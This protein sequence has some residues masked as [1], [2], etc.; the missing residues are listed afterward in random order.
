M[1][2]E[3]EYEVVLHGRK[4]GA[5]LLLMSVYGCFFPEEDENNEGLYKQCFT[6]KEI[7]DYDERFW[8]FATPVEEITE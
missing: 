2:K 4:D 7:K 8:Q 6:E 1:T 5:R 3:K